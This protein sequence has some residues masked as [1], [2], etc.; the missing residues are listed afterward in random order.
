MSVSGNPAKAAE[1]KKLKEQ[2][3]VRA[4]EPAATSRPGLVKRSVKYALTWV[5]FLLVGLLTLVAMVYV[6]ERS[7]GNWGSIMTAYLVPLAVTFLLMP[8]DAFVHRVWR[9]GVVF[10]LAMFSIS[11]ASFVITTVGVAWLLRQTWV[12]EFP[13]ESRVHTW[14]RRRNAR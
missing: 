13:G 2:K 8:F 12:V 10:F 3:K 9:W 5:P 6:S 11:F 14:L 1:Q 7:G 4:E